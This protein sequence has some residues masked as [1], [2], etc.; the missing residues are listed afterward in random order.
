MEYF[1]LVC[2]CTHVSPQVCTLIH[3]HMHKVPECPH[4]QNIPGR[5]VPF[6]NVN[7]DPEERPGAQ[8][9]DP[10]QGRVEEPRAGVDVTRDGPVV[11]LTSEGAQTGQVRL[12]RV[13]AV[14]HATSIEPP[15]LQLCLP[16][17]GLLRLC[18]PN[19]SSLRRLV[20]YW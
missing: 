14:S 4:L 12:L 1:E 11:C 16:L 8:P 3:S 18:G 20:K 17:L 6:V 10:L 7:C 9:V 15:H 2:T 13:R 5:R 19:I